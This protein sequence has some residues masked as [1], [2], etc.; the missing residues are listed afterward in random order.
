[1]IVYITYS[2]MIHKE[3]K[4]D[5][6]NFTRKVNVMY[7]TMSCNSWK[8]NWVERKGVMVCILCEITRLCGIL[9]SVVH[10][11]GHNVLECSFVL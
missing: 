11:Y 10:I 2:C 7:C 5:T 6:S 8:R 1:M 3:S 9:I 4:C